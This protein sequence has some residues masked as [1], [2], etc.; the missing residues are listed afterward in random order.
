MFI[1]ITIILL[2]ALFFANDNK[3]SE[4]FTMQRVTSSIDSNKYLVVNS[5]TDKEKAADLIAQI[6]IFTINFIKKLKDTYLTPAYVV[7]P[8]M[9]EYE[10]DKGKEITIILLERFKPESL[11]ENEP[12]SPDK[13]SYTLNKGQTISL[14]LREKIS[15]Q[16]KFHDIDI[17]K[18]VLLHE[19]G[20]VITPELNHSV[21][22]WTNFRFLLEFCVKYDLYTAVDYNK[23]NV[24]YC[25]LN[26]TYTPTSDTTLSSYF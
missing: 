10:Y 5:Y 15:G 16:N 14:C 21:L 13:T 9:S 11:Q 20:H 25:G 26:V 17:I 3:I 22:F 1:A 7:T 6:N 19:L 12:E 2:F 24:N 4:Y 23:T 18:F 8:H